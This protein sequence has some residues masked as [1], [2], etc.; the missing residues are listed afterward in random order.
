MDIVVARESLF[1]ALRGHTPLQEVQL[2]LAAAPVQEFRGTAMLQII[3]SAI[4]EEV[5]TDVL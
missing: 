1:Q 5:E 2:I 3:L 4:K